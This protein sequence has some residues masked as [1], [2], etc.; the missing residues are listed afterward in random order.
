MIDAS[1]VAARIPIADDGVTIVAIDG[2][3][4]SGKTTFADRLRLA[5][6][7]R[8]RFVHVVH[9]DDFH[10]LRAVRY[11]LGRWSPE[12]FFLDSYDYDAFERQVIQPLRHGD[13]RI[14]VIA[15]DH[16]TDAYVD[17]PMV[18]I[19]PGA[20]VIVEGI[21]AH[22]DELYALWDWSVFLDV[23]VET[24]VARLALRDGSPNDPMAPQLQRYLEG[25]RIYL[26]RCDPKSR[27]TIVLDN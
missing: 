8:A 23:P 25:Q 9:L 6:L 12:G 22:R 24:S 1:A 16:A 21:F 2:V 19:P 3:D 20:V 13:R 18:E 4:G 5:L 17:S 14:R 11:R 26:E 15:T 7:S 10:H 27:A